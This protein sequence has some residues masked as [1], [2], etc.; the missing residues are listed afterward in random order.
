MWPSLSEQRPAVCCEKFIGAGLIFIIFIISGFSGSFAMTAGPADSLVL[1]ANKGD[2][3]F[4]FSDKEGSFYVGETKGT[5]TH[6]LMGF[7][8]Y[9]EQLFA[10]YSLSVNG[11]ECKR[12]APGTQVALLPWLLQRNYE[13]GIRESV[14]MPDHQD[15][16]AIR[17]EGD[18]LRKITLRLLGHRFERILN[19]DAT[20]IPNKVEI[21]L[22]TAVNPY[23]TVATSGKV[24]GARL[25]SEGLFIETAAGG[26]GAG[27]EED[28]VARRLF[29]A[30]A[31]ASRRKSEKA[32]VQVLSGYDGFL[33]EKK[34]R[35]KELV[36]RSPFTTSD[37]AINK[38]LAWA[39]CSFDALN[40]DEKETRLGKGIYAGYPW[41][42]DYWGRD[43][44]IALRALIVTGRFQLA[45]T[46]LWSFLQHQEMNEENPDYG[47]IPNLVLPDSQLY[48]T[49]D[50][51]PRFLIEAQRYIAYSADSA[52]AREIFPHVKAA[53]LGTLRYRTDSLGFITHGP[54][55]TWMDA[56]G[57]D[58]PY[59]PRGNR[60]NDV[61][62][63]WI[64]ALQSTLQ[65]CQEAGDDD[66][67]KLAAKVYQV[68][69]K[70][71]KEF[72]VH[73]INRDMSGNQPVIFD[74]LHADGEPSEQ[75][76]PN[77]L[78]CL[79]AV[80]RT[81]VRKRALL[82]IFDHLATPYGL[83][84]LDPED[85]R[86]H[87]FHQFEPVYEQDAAYHNGIIWLWNS[88]E[89][90]D[91]MARRFLQDRI[92]PVT[93]NYAYLILHG[94]SLGSLPEL[95][96]AVPRATEYAQQ[97]PD[98]NSFDGLA[99]F[100]QMNI[101]NAA[102]LD[103]NRVPAAS[104]TFSQAW[105]L[106]EFIRSF[107]ESY[108]GIHYRPE[109]GFWLQPAIPSAWNYLSVESQAGVLHLKMTADTPDS[110]EVQYDLEIRNK[111]DHPVKLPFQDKFMKERV[112]LTAAPGLSHYTITSSK[113][114]IRIRCNGKS[115]T[116]GYKP[117]SLVN[118]WQSAYAQKFHFHDVTN[119]QIKG[120]DYYSQ[121]H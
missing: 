94:V 88:G 70:V 116:P 11:R 118:A 2:H 67:G 9:R 25:T 29:V 117:S 39:V 22:N 85:A 26:T 35:L 45:K 107:Y 50:A 112:I 40:M 105:S 75:L 65:L 62:A 19:V 111:G 24:T 53:I 42:Q 82:Q 77:G 23:L 27:K 33:R 73:Y 80:S 101:R 79:D 48:N 72:N 52:F 97:Y 83:M 106:S 31:G 59:S 95:L 16:V 6:F 91:Q 34:E 86:F 113:D 109:T 69:Q 14:F 3:L 17:V 63:L 78:Y 102:D 15:A 56:V 12:D 121:T 61:Q 57:P 89:A 120:R 8:A 58:G 99:R 81:E 110:R 76:R 98:S 55:D 93:K 7:I 44:F 49:A 115:V 108:A 119:I 87:P 5:T 18:E 47:K 100:D 92:Y 103:R 37:S 90:V 10:D 38:A 46:N 30:G 51:T 60:A 41:F 13:D 43:S 68:L 74:A 114:S 32:A 96:D 66:A 21:L 104:G 84:S 28:E 20:Q 36:S 71:K 54:A 64:R 1:H 4:H